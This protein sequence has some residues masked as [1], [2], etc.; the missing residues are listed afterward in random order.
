MLVGGVCGAVSL[1]GEGACVAWSRSIAVTRML[2]FSYK[3]TGSLEPRLKQP[4]NY[5]LDDF[6][7]S[8]LEFTSGTRIVGIESDF[9]CLLK[10]PIPTQRFATSFAPLPSPL[11]F[12]FS[13]P[14]IYCAAALPAL[15]ASSAG[16]LPAKF[17]IIFPTAKM[18]SAT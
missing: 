14:I 1:G 10:L 2:L 7:R 5:V 16:G 17:Q 15:Y 13:H 4:N 8:C 3:Y 12:Y 11:K 6:L 18:Q 9:A